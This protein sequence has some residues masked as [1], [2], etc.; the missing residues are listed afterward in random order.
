MPVK[1]AESCVAV[2]AGQVTML[3]FVPGTLAHAG[4]PPGT[5][6]PPHNCN[7]G[8]LAPAPPI[9]TSVCTFTSSWIRSP[10]CTFVVPIGCQTV[11]PE[12]AAQVPGTWVETES[13]VAIGLSSWIV[14]L[15]NA[16]R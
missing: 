10:V 6:M 15:T 7:C 3:Q 4:E 2:L 14:E 16:C 12:R 9:V 5:W 1:C 11:A 13:H 8:R